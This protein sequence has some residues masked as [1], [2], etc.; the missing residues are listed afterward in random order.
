MPLLHRK[1]RARSGQVSSLQLDADDRI[2]DVIDVDH[3]FVRYRLHRVPTMAL[4]YTLF[5]KVPTIEGIQTTLNA[6]GLLSA[7]VLTICAVLPFAYGHDDYQQ[8]IERWNSTTWISTDGKTLYL[9]DDP[10]RATLPYADK[11][12]SFHERWATAFTMLSISLVLVVVLSAAIS[13]AT[14]RE[15]HTRKVE[16]GTLVRWWALIRW[17]LM[18]S[19][20]TLV[21]GIIQTCLTINSQLLLFLPRAPG[22]Y[23]LGYGPLDMLTGSN[24]GVDD[25][26]T[27]YSTNV[28]AP[29]RPPARPPPAR[30][31]SA[32]SRGVSPWPALQF[33]LVFLVPLFVAILLMGCAFQ[34][35]IDSALAAARRPQPVS[36]AD[37][38]KPKPAVDQIDLTS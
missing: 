27:S 15:P 10:R 11:Y 24:A 6:M 3:P 8:A 1:P 30:A 33:L 28:R 38:G 36:R 19:F 21:I 7:L 5:I 14:F 31:G 4:W 34:G 29:T 32:H 13:Q 37:E 26:N 20:V 17:V 12:R 35:P 16:P 9:P 22:P 2:I 18:Y 25:P 23:P